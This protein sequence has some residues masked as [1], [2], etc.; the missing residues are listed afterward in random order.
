MSVLTETETSE[1]IQQNEEQEIVTQQTEEQRTVEQGT[2]PPAPNTED[3]NKNGKFDFEKFKSNLEC[4]SIL[5]A[6]IGVISTGLV[7]VLSLGRYIHFSFDI[8]YYD[9]KLTNTDIIVFVLSILFCAMAIMY[10]FVTNDFKN[11]RLDKIA[12]SSNDQNK[13]KKKLAVNRVLLSII[14]ILV[15]PVVFYFGYKLI[16]GFNAVILLKN[17]IMTLFGYSCTVVISWSCT[18]LTGDINLKIF[19]KVFS[20][21][22]F[23]YICFAFMNINYKEAK[24]QR[25]FEII[26]SENNEGQPQEYVVISKGSSY[27]AYQCST[28]EQEA[29]KVLVIHTDLHRYFPLDDTETRLTIFDEYQLCKYGKPLDTD[30]ENNSDAYQSSEE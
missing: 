25:E 11:K 6:L 9:F 16:C 5:S 3:N 29:G 13:I 24:N 2:E 21:V 26:A 17:I 4:I 1:N 14:P 12:K 15:Y 23:F 10:C 20:A 8:N 27:S 22:I 18:I 28:E 30:E 19:I 7:K